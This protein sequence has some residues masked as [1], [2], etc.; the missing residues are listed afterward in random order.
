MKDWGPVGPMAPPMGPN[1]NKYFKYL[2]Q[3][4]I[5]TQQPVFEKNTYLYNKYNNLIP[6]Y[7]VHN[8]SPTIP[9]SFIIPKIIINDT[10]EG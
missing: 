6:P 8:D 3:K 4:N 9:K 1:I 7:K 2:Q 10:D 5:H